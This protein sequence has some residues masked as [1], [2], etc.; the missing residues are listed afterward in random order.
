MAHNSIAFDDPLGMTLDPIGPKAT[1]LRGDPFESG[2]VLFEDPI[3]E[4][5]VWECT[6][7]AFS[8]RRDDFREVVTII[9]GRGR[10]HDEDGNV[11]EF[12][13]GS[14]LALPEGWVGEWEIDE[15]V[16]KV[17]VVS[18]STPRS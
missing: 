13:P 6:P 4:A 10:L 14:A 8:A 18:Y 11:T 12:G 9:K 5:G 2:K 15:T 1:A 7:G 3:T 17:Y 16:R